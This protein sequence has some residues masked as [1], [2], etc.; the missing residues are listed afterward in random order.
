MLRKIWIVLGVV[1]L[2][3]SVPSG[4]R[5][6][7]GDTATE[8]VR[9]V[10]D[11]GRNG[12]S[13]RLAD[14]LFSTPVSYPAGDWAYSVAVGDFDGNGQQDLVTANAGPYGGP[15]SVTVLLGNGDGTFAAA[16]SFAGDDRFF[17]VA[18]GD[19]DDDGRQDVVT[20]HIRPTSLNG[21]VSLLRGN[22]DGTFAP[23]VSY[24]VGYYPFSVAVGD[25]NGDGRE[26]LVTANEVNLV[27]L[28]GNGD[29][30]FAAARSYPA[31]DSPYSVAVGDFDGNGWQDLVTANE[32][33]NQFTVLLGNGD[34][35]FASPLSYTLGDDPLH[36]Y[37]PFSVAVGDFDGDGQQDIVSANHVVDEWTG[38]PVFGDVTVMLGNG[39]GAFAP[40]VS[41]PVGDWPWSVAVGDF[42]RDGR[43]DLVTANQVT[44]NQGY[45]DVTV[46]LGNG[47][48]TFAAA[49]SYPAGDYP[50]SVAVGD[51]DGNGWQDLVTANIRSDDVTVLINQSETVLT[52][53]F[54]IKPDGFPNSVNPRSRGVI[55]VAIIGSDTFDVAEIDVTT[56]A[57]G[58]GGAPI[59]H[60]NGHLQDVNYDGI[61][62]LLLH[63]RTQDTGIVCGDESAILT[64]ETLD[65]QPFEGS[66]SITTVG[67]RETRR[68]AIWMKDQDTPDVPQRNGP[69]NIERR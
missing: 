20:G 36:Y 60:L 31:G 39:D 45:D 50:N 1:A 34:G 44:A 59:A 49:R 23:A 24:P 26:D 54:D 35:T 63:F 11:A 13:N 66:D 46:L 28:L 10:A 32:F 62:D 30:T 48:G 47:D 3:S 19:F 27:V 56:L 69:V 57:F 9:A 64:G 53:F 42:N 22:G 25:F 40:A 38:I 33:M 18:V 41:Y 17:C 61:M 2:I 6:G 55:P 51:F 4:L 12:R 37:Y 5:A 58:P 7:V 16:V 8:I 43:Q 52:A 14:D 65:G 67:C 68:P 15:G 21:R 29:G